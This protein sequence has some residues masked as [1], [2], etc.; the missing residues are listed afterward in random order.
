MVTHRPL[1]IHHTHEPCN[2]EK[3]KLENCH[4]VI[5]LFF[6]PMVRVT[7]SWYPIAPFGYALEA[8]IAHL[9][10]RRLVSHGA[11]IS[12]SVEVKGGAQNKAVGQQPYCAERRYTW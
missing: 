1:S 11:S 8:C 6:I 4:Q 3:K 10:P 2:L 9:Q 5:W 12:R 7:Q